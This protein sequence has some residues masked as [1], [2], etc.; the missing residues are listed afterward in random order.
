MGDLTWCDLED[1]NGG[2]PSCLF[3]VG[4]VLDGSW[5]LTVAPSQP[6]FFFFFLSLFLLPCDLNFHNTLLKGFSWFVLLSILRGDR[7]PKQTLK[8]CDL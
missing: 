8:G 6:L 5:P 4:M 7:P 3:M 2:A 1:R